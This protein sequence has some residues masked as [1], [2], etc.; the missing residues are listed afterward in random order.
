MQI[1]RHS[2]NTRVLMFVFM[3]FSLDSK[4]D[5]GTK[6]CD[7][8]NLSHKAMQIIPC[9]PWTLTVKWN[10]L[11]SAININ[12]HSLTPNILTRDIEHHELYSQKSLYL[13]SRFDTFP[14]AEVNNDPGGYETEHHLIAD[15]ARLVQPPGQTEHFMPG[16]ENTRDVPIRKDNVFQTQQWYIWRTSEKL[17]LVVC[18]L[19]NNSNIS[20]LDLHRPCTVKVRKKINKW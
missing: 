1:S 20:Y 16:R 9:T 2:E 4:A 7:Y 18:K 13:A 10:I 6:C 3:F 19:K 14:H 15:V 5:L 17:H 8:L 11:C 12:L